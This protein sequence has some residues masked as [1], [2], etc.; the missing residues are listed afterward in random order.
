M[1][2]LR[3]SVAALLEVYG[4]VMFLLAPNQFTLYECKLISPTENTE[5][6]GAIFLSI[7]YLDLQA[8]SH[9][10]TTELPDEIMIANSNS[11]AIHHL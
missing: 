3:R 9:L 4:S 1:R 8:Y 11:S 5:A 2:I 6:E 10:P 7:R